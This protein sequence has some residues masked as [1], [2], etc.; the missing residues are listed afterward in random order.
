MSF[1]FVI[2]PEVSHIAKSLTDQYLEET[3]KYCKLLLE[4]VIGGERKY[5]TCILLNFGDDKKWNDWITK[6]K[7]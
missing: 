6:S 7:N 5:K 2:E 4:D 3:V 1:I